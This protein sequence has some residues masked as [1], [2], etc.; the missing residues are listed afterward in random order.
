MNDIA[1]LETVHP[2]Q[3]KQLAFDRLLG[4]E[5]NKSRLLQEL[6]GLLDPRQVDNWLRRHHP[7]GLAMQE[8]CSRR[9]PLIL[10]CGDVGCGK[11]ALAD[12]IGSPV[13]TAIDRRVVSMETPSDL[14][15]WGHVGELS[16]RVTMAFAQARRRAK[17]IG[18]GVLIIDEADDVTT[19]RSQNQAH[20][21]DR[22][23][24]NV[25]IKQVDQLVRTDTALAVLLITNRPG[26]MDP[27]VRRR[28]SLVLEFHRPDRQA[29]GALFASLLGDIHVSAGE[30]ER[31]VVASERPDV[32]FSYSDL[33]QALPAAVLREAQARDIPVSVRLVMECLADLVPSPQLKDDNG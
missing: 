13:A 31:L 4:I 1:L 30:L 5:A 29:R 20:H 21:E 28:A 14:R 32:L 16:A 10:L 12:A 19:A 15:G 33:A 24:L 3:D 26:V 23:G 6:V 8:R 11:T 25:L 18:A 9:A 17:E 22:A 7:R 27:A 2:R